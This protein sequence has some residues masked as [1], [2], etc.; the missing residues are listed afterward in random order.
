ML[1]FSPFYVFIAVKYDFIEDHP[2]GE[3]VH[4]IGEQMTSYWR[5][6]DILQN[7]KQRFIV[8]NYLT[9]RE[10]EFYCRKLMYINNY[11]W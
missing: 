3:Q 9:K 8:D 4:F 5:F 1:Y 11:Y 2:I 7:V 6:R 10:T